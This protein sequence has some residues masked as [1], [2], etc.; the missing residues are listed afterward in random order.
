MK[1]KASSL[2]HIASGQQGK[3]MIFCFG[4]NQCRRLFK[5]KGKNL[6]RIPAAAPL[7]VVLVVAA[8]AGLFGMASLRVE[9]MQRNEQF[10]SAKTSNCVTSQANMSSVYLLFGGIPLDSNA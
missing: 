8:A 9:R 6:H 7:Q 3:S 5:A 1:R 2:I 10:S 4:C